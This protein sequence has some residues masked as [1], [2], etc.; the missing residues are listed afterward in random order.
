[1]G[2]A[3]VLFL[4]SAHIKQK[5]PIHLS[6]NPYTARITATITHYISVGTSHMSDSFCKD[7]TYI[8]LYMASVTSVL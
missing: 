2:S 4:L 3:R 1:M 6:G 7:V 5:H 8:E